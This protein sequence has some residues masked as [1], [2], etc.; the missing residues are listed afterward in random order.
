[1]ERYPE[2]GR[3]HQ[4]ILIQD[5]TNIPQKFVAPGRCRSCNRTEPPHWIAGPDGPRTLCNSCGLEDQTSSYSRYG[6]RQTPKSG[7]P[8]RH[9]V[10]L[11]TEEPSSPS[12]KKTLFQ[13]SDLRSPDSTDPLLLLKRDLEEKEQ[14][15][16]KLREELADARATRARL[17]PEKLSTPTQMVIKLTNLKRESSK[18][19]PQNEDSREKNESKED[20]EI[21]GKMLHEVKREHNDANDMTTGE[22]RK[23]ISYAHVGTCNVCH[24]LGIDCNRS[25]PRCSTCELLN[26]R[27]AA[28]NPLS[29]KDPSRRLVSEAATE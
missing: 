11:P 15:I 10:S 8:L 27:C 1:M 23:E 17:E 13:S 20:E 25:L 4:V 22:F 26:A 5:R 12:V 3:D 14:V 16:A 24:Q 9:S 21:Y 18:H 29:K 19:S 28:F 2:D 7:S 6:Q